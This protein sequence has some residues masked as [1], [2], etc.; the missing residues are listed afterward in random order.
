M[1][2]PEFRDYIADVYGV[3]AMVVKEENIMTYAIEMYFDKETEEKIMSLANKIAGKTAFHE[4]VF[5]R[6]PSFNM[7]S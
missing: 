6:K 5:K 1:N 7:S 3:C 4:R 2:K